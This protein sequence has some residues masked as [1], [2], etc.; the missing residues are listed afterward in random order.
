[1]TKNT[2]IQKIFI[3]GFKSIKDM[4]QP[5]KLEAI[6]ILIGANG[7]GKSNLLS[8]LDFVRDSYNTHN[9]TF[10]SANEMF[11]FGAE[12]TDSMEISLKGDT[13]LYQGEFKTDGN[14]DH[15]VAHEIKVEKL[16]EKQDFL[17]FKTYHF[18]NTTPKSKL[19]SGCSVWDNISLHADGS[20]VA[21]ILHKIKSYAFQYVEYTKDLT[22]TSDQYY[23]L[24]KQQKDLQQ[25]YE[26]F[27]HKR[28]ALRKK[29]RQ[30]E[31]SDGDSANLSKLE[32][33]LDKLFNE[34]WE[35]KY[36]L[37]RTQ[38]KIERI[39]GDSDFET[40]D[41]NN[42]YLNKDIDPNVYIHA[43]TDILYAI[44]AVAPYFDDFVLEKNKDNS[45]ETIPLRWKHKDN[46]EH[47]LTAT[48]LS[49]GTIRFIVLVTLLLQPYPPKVIILDE[50]ELGLHP[51]A[52]QVLA[53]I[54]KS[55]SHKSQIICATQSVEL[56]NC[57]EPENFIVVEQKNGETHFKRQNKDDLEKWLEIYQMGDIWCQNIIG[58]RP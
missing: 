3:K 30:K 11:Y 33:D 20:N 47:V 58:G 24:K 2:H 10:G 42:T 8:V 1:M 5:L 23:A 14:S 57:F 19:R 16:S 56:A 21:S 18:H 28:D 31:E 40:Q 52:I 44:Q 35:I 41:I 26:I 12:Y 53:D 27:R 7:A 25:Q 36:E 22:H 50:P 4:Q 48:Q 17:D 6:N 55:V 34:D 39:T 37:R 43:Y 32:D 9:D 51:D 15:I 49:D 46:F 54:I 45:I 38:R 29:L 13:F